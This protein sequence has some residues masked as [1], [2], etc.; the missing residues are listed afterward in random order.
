M[1][2]TIREEENVTV[3]SLEGNLLGE[4]D[5]KPVLEIV[6]KAIENKIPNFIFDVEKLKYLNST[7]LSI[8]ISTLTKARKNSGELCLVNIQPQLQS[9]LK[10]TKLDTVFPICSSVDQAVE[11]FKTFNK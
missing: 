1:T 4:N 2:I 5:G 11:K 10:I 6:D 3:L 9:L 7:G 8:L